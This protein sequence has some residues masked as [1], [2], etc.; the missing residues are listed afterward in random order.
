MTI[1]IISYFGV[2]Y[3]LWVDEAKVFL[4]LQSIAFLRTPGCALVPNTAEAHQP[5]I[6]EPNYQ[7][8]RTVVN[9]PIVDHAAASL[10]LSVDYAIS[11]MAHLAEPEGFT[12]A[13]LACGAQL[14]LLVG[15]QDQQPQT[16][17][18]SIYL[19][20]IARREY[21][22]IVAQRR[23]RRALHTAPPNK[24]AFAP[25]PRDGCLV[26][27]EMNDWDGPFKYRYRDKN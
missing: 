8:S 15:D 19:M 22:S 3:N 11:P 5:L 9:K 12:P 10:S 16:V 25:T 4:S 24:T 26:Y 1:Y 7:A 2:P 21:E 13:I 14:C 18:N 23:V 20:S 27:R 17:T 6:A